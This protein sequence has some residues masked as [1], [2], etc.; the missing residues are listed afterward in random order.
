MSRRS[1]LVIGSGPIV[2]GQAAEFDYAGRPGVPG[3]ARGRPPRHPRQFEPGDDHDGSRSR[4]CRLPRAADRRLARR[5]HRAR[6]SGRAL[7][8]A[9]RAN[10]PQPRRRTRRSGDDR[11]LRDRAAR[12]ADRYDQ[13]RGRSRALQ[14]CDARDRRARPGERRSSPMSKRPSRLPAVT[15]IRSSCGRPTRSAGPAAA[16][17]ATRPSCARRSRTG[18]DA[19]ADPPGAR[20]NLAAR[21]ER[22]RVRSPARSRRQLHR[23]LQHGEHRSRRRPHRR[24][25]RRRALA[26]ALRSR[27]SDAA[28]REHQRDPR[29]EGAGRL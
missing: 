25:D 19:V 3:L 7:A 16:S 4:R 29:A 6:A 9:R 12:D 14:G 24:F 11:A 23:R 27:I 10:G 17:C 15:I 28:Q 26:D 21:L 22:D 1:V 8:D 20:R 18:L 2:I 5:D 13:A